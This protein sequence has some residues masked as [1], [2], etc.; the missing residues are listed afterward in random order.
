MTN[1][2]N[3]DIFGISINWSASKTAIVLLAIQAILAVVA[4][5]LIM[6][7]ILRRKLSK[8]ASQDVVLTVAEPVTQNTEVIYMPE[9]TQVVVEKVVEKPAEEK[10]RE[11]TYIWIN[12]DNVKKV[13]TVGDAIDHDGL[14][15]TAHFNMEPLE[16]EISDYSV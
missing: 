10:T 15:V 1:L 2:L 9:P 8:Q 5:S 6:Y 13:Y 11:L 16:E 7:L 14:V 12:T 4:I 3:V